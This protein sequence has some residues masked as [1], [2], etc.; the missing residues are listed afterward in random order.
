MKNNLTN[1]KEQYK[2]PVAKEISFFVSSPLL[3]VSNPS[4]EVDPMGGGEE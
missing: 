4:G 1:E 2:A 3:V